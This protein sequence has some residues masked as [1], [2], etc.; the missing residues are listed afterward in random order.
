[1]R[2]LQVLGS[3]A[4]MTTL[5]LFVACSASSRED[6]FTG[7]DSPG[8]SSSSGGGQGG[9]GG[10]PGPGGVG[11]VNLGGGDPGSGGAPPTCIPGGEDDDVDQDGFTPA[12]GDC[13]DCDPN[14]SP[15][16]LEVPTP[17]GEEAYDEDCDMEIDEDD[18]VLCD[19][20]LAIDSQDP[21]LAARAIELCKDSTGPGDWGLTSAAWVQADGA[22]PPPDHLVVFHFG[23]GLLDGFGPNVGTRRG[24][25]LLALSSGAARQPS[26]AGYISPEGFDKLYQGD[27]PDGFPKESP[28]CPGT[29]TGE[30]H[31]SAALEVTL[32]APTNARGFSFDFNFYTH[33]WPQF[34]C[35]MFND[36]FVALLSPYPPGQTDGNI[37]YDSQ[38]NPVSVNNAFLEVCGCPGNP[39]SPCEAGGKLFTCPLG[40][41]DLIGTGFGF[42][43]DTAGSDHG[44]TS[45]LRTTA[46]V[47]P[48]SEISLRFAVY[49]SGDGSLDST[50]LIDQFQW[51][52][53]PG[54]TVGTTPVPQ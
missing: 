24:E 5:A 42:D 6:G 29:F 18:S 7:P 3:I 43:S 1:M 32:R 27:H 50:T 35:S 21:L 15:N 14:V 53:K 36:F 46:P 48:G 38:G 16:S 19:S 44:A 10:E 23:H 25:R 9:A 41:G 39:P 33:E 31:D 52:A 51:I 47:A 8:A 22:P 26:D 28:A 45:W 40:N 34:V 4:A 11:G 13:N 30:P 12:Q 2:R 54:I 17:D 37:S 49:D 20:G